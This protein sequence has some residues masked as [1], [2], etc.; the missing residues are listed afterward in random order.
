[1][2][3]NKMVAVFI[4]GSRDCRNPFFAAQSS[5]K[6]DSLKNDKAPEIER[7]IKLFFMVGPL[8][9]QSFAYKPGRRGDDGNTHDSG[10]YIGK[11]QM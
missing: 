10:Y 11:T 2:T 6:T 4:L 8:F 9:R 3:N 5:E 1:M 7:S